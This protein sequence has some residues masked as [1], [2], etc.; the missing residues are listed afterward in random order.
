MADSIPSQAQSSP[1]D[2][3]DLIATARTHL[4]QHRQS[5]GSELNPMVGR[6]AAWHVHKDLE[7]L[8][9]LTDQ[10]LNEVA[11]LTQRLKA[12]QGALPNSALSFPAW[13]CGAKPIFRGVQGDLLVTGETQP[14]KPLQACCPEG[15]SKGTHL[16]LFSTGDSLSDGGGGGAAD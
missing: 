13:R 15:A 6:T 14:V 9:P 11:E 5:W 16:T 12:A 2:P 3:A 10:L 4:E 1:F 7:K 8:L